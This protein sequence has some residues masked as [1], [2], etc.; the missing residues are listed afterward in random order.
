MGKAKAPHF[1]P[2]LFHFFR[3]LGANNDRAWFTANKERFEQVVRGP[4]IRFVT[5]FQPRLAKISEAF[6]ADPRP[7]GGSIFRINRDTRFSKDKSPYKTH[8][9]LQ[10]RHQRG[11][12]AHAPGYYLHLAPGEVFAGGGIWHPEPD[13]Q[14]KIRDAIAADP[15]GWKK[16][17]EGKKQQALGLHLAGE[18]LQRAP[19][20]FDPEH[21]AIEALKRKDFFVVTNLTEKDALSPDFLDKFVEIA[22]ASYPLLNFLCGALEVEA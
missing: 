19:K 5:D 14:K 6:V 18:S 4:M 16:A 22:V 20:G 8:G 21:P 2:E 1:T 3:E 11:K 15:A 17:T 7:V 13:A 10:F 9:G 12:D